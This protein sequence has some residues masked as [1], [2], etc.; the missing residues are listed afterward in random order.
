MKTKTL[1]NKF[2]SIIDKLGISKRDMRPYA[3]GF[4]TGLA[5]KVHIGAC[6]A[7]MVKPS[8]VDSYWLLPTC[9]DIARTYKLRLFVLPRTKVIEVW[10]C[11]DK[12]T[13]EKLKDAECMDLRG[14]NRARALLC[15]FP[16]ASIND[17]YP[18]SK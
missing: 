15:G 10:F 7:A 13:V 3:A 16:Y 14:A 2:Y 9:K 1:N 4:V 5:E 12:Q 6:A 11:R 8:I 18:I 17:S